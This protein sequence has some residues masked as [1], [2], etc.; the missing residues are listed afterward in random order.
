[1]LHDSVR[2]EMGKAGTKGTKG[3]R[4][5]IIISIIVVRGGARGAGT[6]G[7]GRPEERRYSGA[8]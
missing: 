2:C 8:C 1:M 4:E 5:V 6:R 7:H 3:R